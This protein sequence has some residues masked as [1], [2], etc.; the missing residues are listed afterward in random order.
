[1]SRMVR[2]LLALARIESDQLHLERRPVDLAALVE[3]VRRMFAVQ[4]SEAEVELVVETAP[5]PPVPGDPDRLLQL[6]A[7]LVDNAVAHT[8][9]GGRVTLSLQRA[10]E[11]ALVQVRDTGPGMDEAEAAR[12]F[13]RFYQVD[14]SRS[15]E[16]RGTGLG[17]AIVRQLAEAHNGRV[18]V[19]SRL[20]EGSTFTV[21]LPLHET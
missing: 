14:K 2:Q 19:N 5:L 20:G 1:M 4:A 6:F 13:E 18:Q 10:G 15:G 12:I 9:P 17:L 7:N 21:H 11:M 3:E 16:R 8:P